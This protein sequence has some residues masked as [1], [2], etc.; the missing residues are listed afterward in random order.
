M[1]GYEAVKRALY[2]SGIS[3]TDKLVLIAIADHVGPSGVCWPSL[4]RIAGIIGRNERTVRR[5]I[6]KLEEGRYIKVTRRRYR[7]NVYQVL[8][9]P[10]LDISDVVLD[11]YDNSVLDTGDTVLDI[12]DT[13]MSKMSNEQTKNKPTEQTKEQ[14]SAASDSPYWQIPATLETDDFIR[15]WHAWLTYVN[16]KGITLTETQAALALAELEGWGV[17]RAVGAIQESI[18]R[19]WRSIYEPKQGKQ[20]A[21]GADAAWAEVWTGSKF[22]IPSDEKAKATIKRMGGMS[23]LRASAKRDIDWL[24]KEFINEYNG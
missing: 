22:V 7:G 5:I 24:R 13:K 12:S 15:S 10:V 21:N 11:I 16:E 23:R 8:D 14:N 20:A 6:D 17:K 18:K 1:N 2:A 4:E 19:G 9:F 3:A